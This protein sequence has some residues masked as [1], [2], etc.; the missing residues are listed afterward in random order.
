MPVLNVQNA[1]VSFADR[2]IFH[3]VNFSV[4]KN[5]KIGLIGANGCG[6]T[7]L[8]NLIT[9]ALEPTDGKVIMSSGLRLGYVEQHACIG[10]P[11]TVY[12]ELLTVFAPLMEM[13]RELEEI[14]RKV[15]LT[16]GKVPE[17]LERQHA[18]NEAYAA[19][20]G[21][22]Y[23]SRAHAALA[24]L[25]FTKAEEDLPVS[26]LSGGQ[27]TKLS[28]GKLLMSAPELMLLDEPTNH[29]DTES[30]EW[31][32]DFL[33]KFAGA[34]I[35]ISHDRYF[36]DKVTSRTFEIT[37]KKLYSGK[38]PYSTYVKNK[39]LRLETDRREYEKG[40]TEVNR[41]KKMIEQQ[42]QFNQE[43]NYITI[44][45]K[46]KQIQRI[47]DSL[48]ELPPKE[49]DFKLRFGEVVRSGD[50]VLIAEDLCK[51]YDGKTLFRHVDL[52][53]FRG[54]RV[55]LLGPN[56]CG[57]STLLGQIMNRVPKDAGLVR[58]GQNVRVGYFEQTQSALM[59]DRSVLEE[60]YASFPHLTVPQCRTLLG[61][62]NFRGE[63]VEKNMKTVSGGER[64]RVAL[65]KLILQKPNFLILD[66]PTNHLDAASRE[67]LEDALASY[68]GTILCVSHDRYF[69]NRIA[70]RIIYFNG[71][72]VLA[73]EGNYDTYVNTIR[74]SA[75]D[76]AAA[77]TTEKKPN[78]Y[79]QR[80]EL[81]RAERK[82]QSR[83]AKIEG[84]LQ[85][86]EEEK[87]AVSALLSTPETASDYE[88]VLEF[89]A[90]L[91]ALEREN[92]ALETEWLTLSETEQA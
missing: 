36:L 75:A 67:V 34:L 32:E 53:L 51:A 85:A 7:T 50:E 5:D 12:E 22:T 45:S 20:G 69:V 43:R 21:L 30:C 88:K 73:L 58:F 63:D 44:A 1:A 35:V 70:N 28:L 27:R 76:A 42:K 49:H 40:M 41:N 89:T 39:A 25:G 72:S 84:R 62:F 18:L 92:G 29:L 71:T 79:L 81:E 74:A 46:E 77:Q 6:K 13:E 33:Q 38:G 15:E 26:A 56:G 87:N 10:S 17:Y 55:F 82:R 57:K 14:H 11:R 16:D 37:A 83:L 4:E 19:A 86:I 78:A 61:A 68:E 60:I 2:E 91:E 64:A 24:G 31:L 90:R 8:F 47:L 48:P 23:V 52:R 66:E 54:D 65:L 59:Q 80:K 3:D 9:G